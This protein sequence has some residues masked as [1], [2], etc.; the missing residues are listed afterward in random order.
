MIR[1][2]EQ[3][4]VFTLPFLDEDP[5]ELHV[6]YA[7]DGKTVLEKEL[8]DCELKG[9]V[10]TVHLSEKDTS[11]FRANA[12]Y[13]VQIAVRFDGSVFRSDIITGTVTRS[14]DNTTP[15]FPFPDGSDFIMSVP[16]F[17]REDR[18]TWALAKAIEHAVG[19]F[20]NDVRTADLYLTDVESMPEWALDEYAYGNGVHWYDV[21]ASLYRKRMWAMDAKTMRRCLGT[22]EGVERLIRGVYDKGV[23][24]EWF[25]YGGEPYHFRIR[26]YGETGSETMTWAK[27]AADTAKNCRSILDSFSFGIDEGISLSER[28]VTGMSI[29]P[30]CGAENVRCGDAAAL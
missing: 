29:Y 26:V 3:T 13:S 30:K 24:E 25:D 17:L 1:A 7:Q 27:A 23:V 4:Q 22:R 8:E 2:A 12:A 18:N 28:I 11:P 5:D 21:D 6:T 9:G 15:D 10:L 16:A 19:Q 20:L 14:P